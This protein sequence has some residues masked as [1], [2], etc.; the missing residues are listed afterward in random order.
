MHQI[1]SVAKGGL[2]LAVVQQ[3]L[4][5]NPDEKI[6]DGNSR[7]RKKTHNEASGPTQVFYDFENNIVRRQE[8][9]IWGSGEFK[10]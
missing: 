10:L 8:M 7:S 3:T 5:Q 1:L 9:V 6:Q 4:E 2:M